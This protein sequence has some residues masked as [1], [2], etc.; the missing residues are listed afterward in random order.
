[1]AAETRTGDVITIGID[2]GTT[3]SASYSGIAWASSRNPTSIEVV[4]DWKTVLDHSSDAQKVPTQLCYSSDRDTSWGYSIPAGE[5]TLKWFKLLILDE[6]DIPTD[7]ANSSQLQHTR[8]L[9][10]TMKKDPVDA[11]GCFLRYIWN[12]AIS[13]IARSI[14]RELLQ[15][16]RFHVVLTIPAVWPPYTRQRMMQAV[17]AS[18][19]LNP[20]DCGNTTVRFISEPEAAALSTMWD[21]SDTSTVKAGDTM[22]ICDAGGGTVDLISYVIESTHPFVVKECVGGYGELCGGVF[23]DEEFLKLIRDKV[24]PGSWSSVGIAELGK[25]LNDEWEYAIKPQFSNQKQT[26]QVG[27]P[28]SCSGLTPG[29]NLKRRKTIDLSSDEIFS[30]YNPIISKIENLV[31]SQIN[32]VQKKLQKS[33]N[34]I[35]LVG[36]FGRSPYLLTRLDTN[37]GVKVL[38]S[39]EDK[40]W[41]AI[42]RGAVICGITGHS[43]PPSLGVE[44][45]ARIAGRS[46]GG[47]DKHPISARGAS[48]IRE[49]LVRGEDMLTKK[50]VRCRF[51]RLYSGRIGEIQDRIFACSESAPPEVWKPSDGP[52]CVIRWTRDIDIESLPTYTNPLG[53]NPSQA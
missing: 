30:V 12:H 4:G 53:K 2:F 22:V 39:Q 23:L 47:I 17:R 43:P 18:G 10:E 40:P 41:T 31:R 28:E 8:K 19:I 1:M 46:Y 6:E 14:G 13:C 50:R 9:L 48:C 29:R 3:N 34:Y 45:G 27:L 7:I 20:R 21:V 15:K 26:W 35:V 16:S 25:F 24:T 38:Q 44:I 52:L 32:A 33:P 5:D 11:I 37:L 51:S 36:G 42:C 49:V